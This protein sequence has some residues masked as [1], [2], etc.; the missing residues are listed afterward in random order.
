MNILFMSL[1]NYQTIYFH[2]LYPDLLRQFVLR[3]DNL[4]ILSPIER[5]SAEAER[6]IE[7][8]NV[9]I[10]K[11]RIWNMQKTNLLGKNFY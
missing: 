4:Y 9:K 3:G 6:V 5:Q 1:T 8:K 10:V 7:E 11:I 2:S